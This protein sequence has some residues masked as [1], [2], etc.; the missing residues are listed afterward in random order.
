[1]QRAAIEAE[2]SEGSDQALVDRIELI[3]ARGQRARRQLLLQPLPLEHG[4]LE[5]RGRRVGVELE[6]LGRS[7]SI[8]SQVEAAIEVFVLALPASAQIVPGEFGD[9]ETAQQ[10]LAADDVLDRLIAQADQVLCCGLEIRLDLC[11]AESVVRRLVPIGLAVDGV[12]VEA[13]FRR[14]ALPVGALGGADPFH[15]VG[16][17]ASADAEAPRPHSVY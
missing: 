6:K 13:Q 2:A 8:V 4:G 11:Q 12:V 1:M 14:L 15:I 10:R 9:G 5:E 3:G 7:L 17:G 16:S